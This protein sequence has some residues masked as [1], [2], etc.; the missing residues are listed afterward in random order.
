MRG[1]KTDLHRPLLLRQVP[2]VRYELH[3]QL[4]LRLTVSTMYGQWNRQK[5][6][7][8]QRLLDVE[9]QLARGSN[10]ASRLSEGWKCLCSDC[11]YAVNMVTNYASR[12]HC[13][14]CYRPRAKA[15]N[16]P[17]HGKIVVVREKARDLNMGDGVTDK[18][19]KKREARA[20]RRQKLTDFKKK[21]ELEN[22]RVSPAVAQTPVEV[23]TVA[24]I[25]PGNAAPGPIATAM[26]RAALSTSTSPTSST[27][28]T[29][30]DELRVQI[31]LLLP[32]AAKTIV[33][34][35]AQEGVPVALELKSPESIMAKTIGD[36]GPSAKVARVTELQTTIAKLKSML[37]TS[38]GSGEAMDDIEVALKAKLE[39]AESALTKAQKDAP[40]QLSELKAVLEAKSSYEVSMQTRKDTQQR[41]VTKATER[42]AQR[43]KH[44]QALKDQ[45]TALENGLTKLETVNN[46][47]H[48]ARAAA[49]TAV[50]T[51]VLALFDVKI[52]ALQATGTV[53]NQVPV[54][55]QP[56][57]PPPGGGQSS[58][59]VLALASAPAQQSAAPG[60]LAEL[61]EYKKKFA[62]LQ[63]GMQ[64]ATYAFEQQFSRSFDDI[65][66][67]ML[68]PTEIPESD[69]LTAYGSI[70][71]NLQSWAVAGTN[72]PF[73][74]EALDL[75][76][77]P[78]HDAVDVARKLLGGV[79]DKWYKDEQPQPAAVVPRQFALHL[80]H[81]L[82]NVKQV[83]EG[84]EEKK[85]IDLLA[86]KGQEAI[87]AS[88]KRLR[89]EG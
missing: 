78:S 28:L 48:A 80:M 83:F 40:S 50:D 22:A 18:E 62:A 29:L 58:G 23:C 33:E 68:P 76:A 79:W 37:E 19:A 14:G 60:T 59:G 31:P 67:E 6:T 65:L 5:M 13:N 7:L 43:Q 49:Q 34:S 69:M 12:T 53:Q 27:K 32:N 73:D 30:P 87:R 57:A 46:D 9:A 61:E 77:G 1:R 11:T 81:C 39:T 25:P 54:G 38:S 47:A 20:K 88:A 8:A 64:K 10:G 89:T 75:M 72:Q 63:A 3:T 84:Q 24:V 2:G 71:R 52:A 45:V 36:R 44:I 85:A 26:P 17:P 74:W 86:A 21:K 66:P 42:K 82:N 41:G 55:A 51:K 15:Q 4:D 70:Y 35:L 56:Q 16:P